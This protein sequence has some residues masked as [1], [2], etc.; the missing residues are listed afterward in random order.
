MC[1]RPVLGPLRRVPKPH[2]HFKP[3]FCIKILRIRAR[4]VRCQCSLKTA[5]TVLM[6]VAVTTVRSA[7]PYSLN[8]T[9]SRPSTVHDFMPLP[10]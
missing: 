5:A 2:T 9:D 6:L 7:P 8:S 4:M 3:S 1:G 10:N